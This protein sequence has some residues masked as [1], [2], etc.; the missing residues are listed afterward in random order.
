MTTPQDPQAQLDATIDSILDIEQPLW[1]VLEDIQRHLPPQQPESAP[2]A[3]A[4]AR[5]ATLSRYPLHDLNAYLAKIRVEQQQR[6][7]ADQ[8]AKRAQ[9]AAKE[10][11]KEAARFYNKK[12]AQAD[13]AYWL[14]MDYWKLEEAV[15]LLLGRDP[16][17]VTRRAVLREVESTKFL[18]GPPMSQFLR[19]Y[20]TLFS[21]ASRSTAL[22]QSPQISP[23]T[24]VEWAISR[25]GFEP[26]QELLTAVRPVKAQPAAE[27]A[28]SAA[29][30]SDVAHSI[31][32]A[33]RRD[34]MSPVIEEAQRRCGKP[35]DTAAVWAEL[36]VM[37]EAKVSPMRGC[38]EDGIQFLKDGQAATLTRESLRKRLKRAKDRAGG[39]D[40]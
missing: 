7:A 26:P 13:Y 16:R 20:E 38:T 8:A 3:R 39:A 18:T 15:A 23:A 22:T 36:L 21:I 14:R 32:D 25:S 4:R 5:R 29:E 1:R 40:R 35:Y 37:A 30:R 27:S 31:G 34:A 28:T 2:Y 10:A 24:A 6:Q 19:D 11:S 9:K 12:E 33:E 17:V